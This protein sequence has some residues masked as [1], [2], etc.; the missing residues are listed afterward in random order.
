MK[1]ALTRMIALL[2]VLSCAFTLFGCAEEEET[3]SRRRKSR[4]ETTEEYSAFD[5][6]AEAEGTEEA[7]PENTPTVPGPHQDAPPVEYVPGSYGMPAIELMELTYDE[8]SQLRWDYAETED[9]E[10]WLFRTSSCSCDF[11]FVFDGEFQ[12]PSAKPAVMNIED[13]QDNGYAYLTQDIQ[14]CNA[15]YQLPDEIAEKIEP[16]DGGLSASFILN[17]YP[18]DIL[19]DGDMDHAGDANMYLIQVRQED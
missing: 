8:L 12:D 13:A 14:I 17:D 16:M 2:M 7:L 10:R 19:F 5:E 6:N 15:A 11:M 9:G 1:K 3:S 18:V 4:K